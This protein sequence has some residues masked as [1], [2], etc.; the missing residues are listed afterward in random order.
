MP[1][2]FLQILIYTILSFLIRIYKPIIITA[3][4]ELTTLADRWYFY[5]SNKLG[6]TIFGY[7]QDLLQIIKIQLQTKLNKHLLVRWKI[8]N[9]TFDRGP[10]ITEQ[11][12]TAR[13]AH[14]RRCPRRGVA[15]SS[16]AG[17][18]REGPRTMAVLR[19]RP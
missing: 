16:D 9:Q 12:T 13:R 8:E 17:P 3:N 14:H 6:L 15:Q 1:Q 2:E 11:P 18:R 10:L 4:C 19:E 5:E 7:L